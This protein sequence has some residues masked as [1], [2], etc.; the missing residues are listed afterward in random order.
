MKK[1]LNDP[2]NYVDE[3]LEGLCAAHPDYYRQCGDNGR[4]IARASDAS[5]N[6]VGIVSGGGSGHL[7]VF[8]GYVGTGL[9]DT[10]AIGDVFASPSVEQMSDAMRAADNGAGGLQLYC[11]YGGDIMNFDMAGEMLEIEGIEYASV[12][13]ADDVASAGTD[14]AEKRRGVAGMVYAFKCAGAKAEEMEDLSEVA[15]VAQKTADACRSIGMAMT[16]C[17]VPQ[18]GK[19]TFEIGDN[20]MEMGMGIHGEP[21]VWRGSIRT[22]DEVAAELMDR[23]LSDK[24]IAKG[25]RVSILI[26]SLGATPPE[27]LYILYRYAKA[28]LQE[29]GASIVMPLV[30]RYA[31]AMEMTGCSMTFCHLDDEL[32]TLLK[33]PAECAFWKV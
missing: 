25:D 4:V 19:P 20:E 21:G 11:N 2:F 13:L 31:T 12:I 29:I 30:G 27:E 1:L 22:A 5:P 8:A 24:P 16:S 6:K 28:R 23:L 33:A 17:T 18:A 9:L 15:R 3:M 7:P 32:E 10:C 14:E 26:N